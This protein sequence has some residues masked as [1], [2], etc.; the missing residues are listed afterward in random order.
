[1]NAFTTVSPDFRIETGPPIAVGSATSTAAANLRSVSL[2]LGSPFGSASTRMMPSLLFQALTRSAGNDFRVTG[3]A[4]IAFRSWSNTI[5]IGATNT[6][7]A[8]FREATR[9]HRTRA[10]RIA[11]SP[12]QIVDRGFQRIDVFLVGRRGVDLVGI[13]RGVQ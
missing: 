6:S 3:S 10:L 5:F 11:R 4:C 2:S 9:G 1:M 12:A 7:C 13:E 8:L